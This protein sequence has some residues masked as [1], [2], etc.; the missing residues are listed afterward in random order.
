[1]DYISRGRVWTNVG[2][3]STMD[4]TGQYGGID[5]GA[6]QIHQRRTPY[7]DGTG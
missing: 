4:G 3:Q 5:N 7:E 6:K 1:M 2:L